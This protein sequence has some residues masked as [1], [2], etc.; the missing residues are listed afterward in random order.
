[1]NGTSS[2]RTWID[3]PGG[4]PFQAFDVLPHRAPVLVELKPQPLAERQEQ[5]DGDGSPRDGG[6]RQDGA[7][8]GEPSRLEEEAEDHVHGPV[9]LHS[10]IFMATTGSRREASRAGK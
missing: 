2:A 7:L 9:L 5:Q 4:I 6:D 10:Y 3:R 1:M 8:A